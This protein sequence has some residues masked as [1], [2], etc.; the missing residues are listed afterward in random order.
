MVI[1]VYSGSQGPGATPMYSGARH[2]I[3]TMPPSTQEYKWVQVNCQQNLMKC[4]GAGVTCDGLA[5][6]PGGVA[7]LLFASCYGN[8]DK[9][10]L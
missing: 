2:L 5:F 4:W 8:M 3:L 7:I 9:P 1:T 10:Q 6:H